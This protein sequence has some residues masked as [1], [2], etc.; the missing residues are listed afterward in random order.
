MS[1][2]AKWSVRGPVRT[3]R[4]ESAGWDVNREEWQPP[5]GFSVVVFRPDGKISESTHHDSTSSFSCSQRLYDAAGE[6]VKIRHSMNE[7]PTGGAV[8]SYDDA[9]RHVRTISVSPDGTERD[10]EACTYDAGGRK[11]KVQLLAPQEPGVTHSYRIEGTEH[12]CGAPGA[13]TMTVRYGPREQPAEV[14]F[15]DTDHRLVTRVVLARDDAGRLLCEE[16]HLGEQTSI[17]NLPAA[18]LLELFGPSQTFCRTTYSYNPKGLLSEQIVRMSAVCEERT[19]FRYDDLDNPSETVMERHRRELG[20]DEDGKMLPTS[21]ASEKEYARFEYRYDAQGNW[22][23]RVVWS[24]REPNP[25]F[26]RSSVERREIS[27]HSL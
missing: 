10:F 20:I 4:T 13:T 7:Q 9:G 11:T 8:Y 16:L 27:Y 22:T 17:P 15:H 2:L 3:L 1:D 25:D 5:R 21:E 26:Q 19:L 14:L 6:L 12:M 18:A 23:E 24:R